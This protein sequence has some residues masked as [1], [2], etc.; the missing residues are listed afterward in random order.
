MFGAT[1]EEKAY[2]APFL[3]LVGMI[4]LGQVTAWFFDGR[5]V[6]WVLGEPAYWVN[7][8]QALIGGALL[9]RYRRFYPLGAPRQAWLALVVGVAVLLLWLAPQELLRASPRYAGFNPFFFGPTGPPYWIT[10]LLRFVKLVIVVPFAEEIFWRGFVLRFVI[11][12][13]FLRVP[14]GTFRWNSFLI[15]TVGFTVEHNLPD[16]PAAALAG[17]LY[18]LVAYRTRSLSSCILA[19]AATNLLLGIYVLRTGQWGFW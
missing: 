15:A 13:N 9:V 5:L 14:F 3:A 10:L 17:A 6:S 4:L 8:A 11:D 16:W 12:P 19:H 2:F 1:P 18:N 7:P